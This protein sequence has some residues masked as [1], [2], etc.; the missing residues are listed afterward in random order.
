MLTG[1][2]LGE[3]DSGDLSAAH[4]QVIEDGWTKTDDG[5]LLLRGLLERYAGDLHAFHDVVALESAV[6]GRGV[7]DWD[8]PMDDARRR[9]PLVRRAFAFAYAALARAREQGFAVL[10]CVSISR[11]DT[12]EAPLTAH[13][14][15]CGVHPELPPYLADPASATEAVAEIGHADLPPRGAR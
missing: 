6:N 14:T 2:D 15:M 3:L 12:D 11:A 10:A 13:V 4:R 5:A 8:L 1:I 7:V 9:Q